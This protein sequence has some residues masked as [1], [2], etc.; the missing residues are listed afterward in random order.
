MFREAV[1]VIGA[2]QFLIVLRILGLTILT[3]RVFRT[4]QD[5]LYDMEK[6]VQ[7]T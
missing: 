5:E 1:A 7:E 2:I 6:D 4:D 3:S